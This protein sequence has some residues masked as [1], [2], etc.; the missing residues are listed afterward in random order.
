MELKRVMN[1]M[2]SFS[3]G[4]YPV[5]DEIELLVRS[6]TARSPENY[7]FPFDASRHGLKKI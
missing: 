3:D 4:S 7:F 1:M 6:N 5:L 2:N